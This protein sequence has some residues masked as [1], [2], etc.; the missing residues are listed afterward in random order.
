MPEGLDEFLLS[1]S[2]HRK[3]MPSDMAGCE[4]QEAG[5]LDDEPVVGAYDA[6]VNR[7]PQVSGVSISNFCRDITCLDTK[8][9][10]L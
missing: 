9:E 1:C 6:Q 3:C 5:R 10:R 8:A 4:C 2:G 7:V